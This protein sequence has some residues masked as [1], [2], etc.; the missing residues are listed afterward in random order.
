MIILAWIGRQR[1]RGLVA[2]VLIGVAVPPLGTVLRPYLTEAVIGL[3]CIAFMRIDLDSF[4]S[5]VRRPGT[6][7]AATLWTSCVMPLLFALGCWLFDVSE[8][9][10]ALFVGLMLQ[11]VASPMMS[12]P[13]FAALMGLDATLVLTTLVASSAITPLTAPAFGALLGLPLTLSPLSHG[14][15]LFAILASSAAVGLVLRWRLGAATIRRRR[16]EID[17]INLLILLVFA[18]AVMGDVGP[19]LVTQPVRLL[20]LT[21]LAFAV[22]FAIV[23]VTFAIFVIGPAGRA[24]PR[25]AL[26]LGMLTAQRNMGLMMISTGGLLPDMTWLYFAVSQFPL[27]LTPQILK[28]VAGAMVARESRPGTSA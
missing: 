27:F 6:V 13:A 2:V 14:A 11:A 20:V 4:R 8:N 19:L 28:P 24:A 10:P 1:A 23:A 3:L 21:L 26:A 25:R 9:N 5:H 16:D 12:A 7:V 22:F 17:G 15:T 18:A